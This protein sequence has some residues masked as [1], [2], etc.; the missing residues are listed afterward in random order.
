MTLFRSRSS[1]QSGAPSGGA[2]SGLVTVLDVG[3]TKI[4]C[5]IAKLKPRGESCVL[6]ERRHRAEEM[7]IGH[8][9]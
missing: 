6:A 8:E 2:G 7:G 4:S 5:V 3:S 9:R 1:G